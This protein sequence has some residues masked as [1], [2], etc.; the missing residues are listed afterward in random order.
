MNLLL[1]NYDYCDH[2]EFYFLLFVLVL[3]FLMVL[4]F[5]Q[6]LVYF[7]IFRICDTRITISEKTYEKSRKTIL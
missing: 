4:H 1:L 5:K 3:L 7:F 6:F 2:L